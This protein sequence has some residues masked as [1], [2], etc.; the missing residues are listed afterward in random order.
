MS[1]SS[2]PQ[3]AHIIKSQ[4][5]I[6]RQKVLHQKVP[7][8]HHLLLLA[9]QLIPPLCTVKLQISSTK[10]LVTNVQALT[11]LQG[12]VNQPNLPITIAL[13]FVN[14]QSKITRAIIIIALLLKH[15]PITKLSQIRLSLG[16]KETLI[17]IHQII[18]MSLLE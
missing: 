1:L 2:A 13:S 7:R 17:T 14:L 6:A 3:Q 18:L 12:I 9:T 11:T 4:R 5:I 15:H 8:C 10:A 16:K